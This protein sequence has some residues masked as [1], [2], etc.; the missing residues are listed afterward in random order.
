M[1][2]I[3]MSRTEHFSRRSIRLRATL[4]H[5]DD[6]IARVMLAAAADA[7]DE[8]AAEQQ[9]DLSGCEPRIRLLQ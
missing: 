8:A 9:A 4:E 7:L 3:E 2:R 6:P 5:L 1:G